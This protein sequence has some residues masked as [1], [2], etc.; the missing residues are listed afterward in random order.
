MLR[1]A[2]RAAPRGV[3]RQ[4]GRVPFTRKAL[5]WLSTSSTD[6]IER[7]TLGQ[8]SYM[9]APLRPYRTDARRLAGLAGPPQRRRDR[10]D[11]G[12]GRGVKPWRH[13]P[14]LDGL[15]A[16]GADFV[17]VP[18]PFEVCL[19]A[20]FSGIWVG[21]CGPQE[22]MRRLLERYPRAEAQSMLATQLPT[23]AKIPFANHVVRTN[24]PLEAVRESITQLA[25]K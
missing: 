9:F 15:L 2:S 18:L 23:R 20:H 5:H 24:L 21:T 1:E 17:E 14:G 19:G 25:T 7:S 10:A 8:W 4:V 6:T 22:Q 16:L 3:M 11:P 13:R 12:R